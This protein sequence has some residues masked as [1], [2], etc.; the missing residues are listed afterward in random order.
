MDES[1]DGIRGRTI[2]W[3]L[4]I[5]AIL[6]AIAALFSGGQT[7][8]ILSTVGSA[9]GDHAGAGGATGQGGSIPASTPRATAAP[10]GGKVAALAA[11][12]PTLM[13]IRTGSIDLEVA[14]LDAALR[15]SD[16]AVA[17]GGGY[18][19]AS[20]R[21]PGNAEGDATVAYRIPGAAWDATLDSIRS[22]ARTIRSEQVK[23][24]EVS[25]QVI[26]LGARI[27]NLRST[28]AALQAIMTKA[29]KISDILAVQDQ[30]TTTRDEIE[31]LVAGRASLEDRAAFGSLTVT[32]R[33]P[34]PVAPSPTPVP[35]AGWNPGKD[36]ELATARLVTIGERSTSIGIWLAIVGL[37]LLIAAAIATVVAWQLVRLARWIV[38]RRDPAGNAA[39]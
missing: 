3:I 10:A 20:T 5:G 17:R 11:V 23:T 25:D 29:T 37:P 14:D 27:A 2:A 6:I 39:T 33:L 30:L 36:V 4:A 15:S 8:T 18:V 9:I 35:K 12:P 13:I 31:R 26:D 32:F 1:I 34:V 16:A 19:D 21:A 28:E 24:E 38:A 7:P 22:T